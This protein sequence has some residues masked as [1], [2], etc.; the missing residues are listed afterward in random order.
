MHGLH[1]FQNKLYDSTQF[2]QCASATNCHGANLAA[3]RQ[4]TLLPNANSTVHTG[5][6]ATAQSLLAVTIIVYC[7]ASS[8]SARIIPAA[9]S[10]PLPATTGHRMGLS[11]S[12]HHS[13]QVTSEWLQWQR[14]E[15]HEACDTYSNSLALLQ[16]VLLW[17]D[18]EPCRTL[19]LRWHYM[20]Q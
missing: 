19:S 14:L 18:Q 12:C 6:P 16:S 3:A 1:R 15:Q 9:D 2:L 8:P 11:P 13:P 10:V 20:Q 7:L 5:M 4:C 17:H